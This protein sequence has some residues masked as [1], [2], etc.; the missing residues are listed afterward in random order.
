MLKP[1]RRTSVPVPFAASMNSAQ[2]LIWKGQTQP[3]PSSH[4]QVPVEHHGLT[5]AMQWRKLVSLKGVGWV[6]RD[7][8]QTGFPPYWTAINS[9]VR[10]ILPQHQ[11]R[12]LCFFPTP[13]YDVP[14]SLP[15]L[16]LPALNSSFFHSSSLT[17]LLVIVSL[18]ENYCFVNHVY[19][20]DMNQ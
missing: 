7:L 5:T 16:S 3:A 10:T 2:R 19:N 9:T 8:G 13:H 18:K 11:A 15:S 20:K 4:S 17:L 6:D 14:A 12:G 1:L